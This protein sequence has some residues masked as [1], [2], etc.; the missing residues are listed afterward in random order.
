MD[1][2]VQLYTQIGAL[3]SG[4]T[5]SIFG[6]GGMGVAADVR[7][8]VR[9]WICDWLTVGLQAGLGVVLTDTMGIGSSRLTQGSSIGYLGLTV[10]FHF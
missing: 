3:V 5:G 9:F 2:R 4:R 8:G 7:V 6:P 10:G 1:P